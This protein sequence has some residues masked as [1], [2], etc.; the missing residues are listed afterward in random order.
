LGKKKI[1]SKGLK[2]RASELLERSLPPTIAMGR[3]RAVSLWKE[4]GMFAR[5]INVAQCLPY[6]KVQ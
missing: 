1:A 6:S 4:I 2:I 5:T 3:Y